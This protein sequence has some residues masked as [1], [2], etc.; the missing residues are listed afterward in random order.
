M[1]EILKAIPDTMTNAQIAAML[2]TISSSFS[3]GDPLASSMHLNGAQG[4]I[5]ARALM[6][7]ENRSIN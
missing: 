5:L 1:D 2:A 3:G 4:M 6:E 7:M